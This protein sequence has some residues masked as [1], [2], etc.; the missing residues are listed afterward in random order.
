MKKKERKKIKIIAR[1]MNNLN[2]SIVDFYLM[3]TVV[4]IELNQQKIVINVSIQNKY[5]C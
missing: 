3:V 2:S 1:G 4:W 5:L